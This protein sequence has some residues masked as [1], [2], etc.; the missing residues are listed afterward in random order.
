MD[1]LKE[2]KQSIS[3]IIQNKE[4][5]NKVIVN[6]QY[7]LKEKQCLLKQRGDFIK[8]NVKDAKYQELR[9]FKENSPGRIDPTDEYL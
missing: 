3:D 8:K 2:L 6:Y 9:N 5:S 7:I 4:M 1:N